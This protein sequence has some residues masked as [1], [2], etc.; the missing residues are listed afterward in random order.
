MLNIGNTNF[1]IRG[2]GMVSLSMKNE[3]GSKANKLISLE[4]FSQAVRSSDDS[5]ELPLLPNGI[6]KWKQKGDYVVAAIEYPEQIIQNFNYKDNMYSVPVPRSVWL[7]LLSL[8]NRGAYRYKIHKTHIF[9]L[10]T[11]LLS[12][13][14]DMYMWPFTNY[15]TTFGPGICWGSHQSYADIQNDCSIRNISSMYSMYFNAIFNDHL[16]WDMTLP[17]DAEGIGDSKYV[18]YLNGKQSFDVS[19]LHNENTTFS[20]AVDNLLGHGTRR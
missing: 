7:T 5:F 14:Q 12:E 19:M 2:D 1:T 4:S 3:D 18:Q 20:R 10:T 15:A 13:G 16:R 9:S 11:P 17:P 6:R 8:N